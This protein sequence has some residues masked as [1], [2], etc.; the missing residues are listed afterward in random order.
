MCSFQAL[1]FLGQPGKILVNL[2]GLAVFFG[3]GKKKESCLNRKTKRILLDD[4][5]E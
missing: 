4:D 1:V 5:E 3:E 2:I